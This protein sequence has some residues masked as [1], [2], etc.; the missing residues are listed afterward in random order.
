MIGWR[1]P[2]SARGQR[3]DRL[4]GAAVQDYFSGMHAPCW[5]RCA[6]AVPEALGQ[7]L[8]NHVGHGLDG[9][10]GVDAC[11]CGKDGGICHIQVAHL[12]ECKNAR[13]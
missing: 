6:L 3:Y 2:I 11:R 12:Q 13:R 10:H 9:D 5:E 4:K 1:P 8:G 7:A